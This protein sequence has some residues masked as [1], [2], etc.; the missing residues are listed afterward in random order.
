MGDAHH[1]ESNARI[2]G[3]KEDEKLDRL[4]FLWEEYK[5]RHELCWKLIFQITVAVV[6]I[7]V[8]P[9]TKENIAKS[10]GDWILALPAIAFILALFSR[11]RVSRELFILQIIRKK[12]RAMQYEVYGIEYPCDDNDKFARDVKLYFL[13]LGLMCIVEM[14]AIKFPAARVV[15]T[16]L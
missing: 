6:A 11:K 4:K 8:I 14:I 5:Y 10:I 9:Y 12:Y 15:I 1:D 7:L 13:L 16:F 2:S 3:L